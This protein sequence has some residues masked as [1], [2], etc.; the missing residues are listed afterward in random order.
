M[1]LYLTEYEARDT[2]DVRMYVRMYVSTEII[3]GELDIMLFTV[4]THPRTLMRTPPRNFGLPSR[5]LYNFA[6]GQIDS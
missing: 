6:P 3:L 4:I 2:R 5:E 1:S